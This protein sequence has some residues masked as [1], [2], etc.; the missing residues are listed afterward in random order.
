MDSG[1]WQATVDEVAGVGHNLATKP[2]PVSQCTETLA[3]LYSFFFF[4]CAV[5]CCEACRT[6]VP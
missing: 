5:L 1:A 6:L 3:Y 2:P 4:S